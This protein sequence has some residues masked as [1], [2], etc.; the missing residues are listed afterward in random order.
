MSLEERIV[1]AV[2][3]REGVDPL[4]LETPL[5]EA[6]DTGVLEALDRGTGDRQDGPY[7][8]VEFVYYGYTVGID[9]TG[10]VTIT[11]RTGATDEGSMKTSDHS[12][13]SLSA[14]MARRM[15]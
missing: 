13:E 10:N 11:E 8:L 15:R 1:S 12:L 14:E 4:D 9:G 2:A 3:D 7:P 5:N 6:V